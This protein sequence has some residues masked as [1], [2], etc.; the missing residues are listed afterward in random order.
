M[1]LFFSLVMDAIY[2]LNTLR[3]CSCF[4]IFCFLHAGKKIVKIVSSVQKNSKELVKASKRNRSSELELKLDELR[5]ELSAIHGGIFPHSVLSTQQISRLSSQKPV[6]M[7]EV[8]AL[9][10]GSIYVYYTPLSILF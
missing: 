6:T 8:T 10:L 1:I 4:Y 7:K 3:I 5:K 2:S 9:L